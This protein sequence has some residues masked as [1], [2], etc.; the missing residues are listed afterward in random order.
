MMSDV[1]RILVVLAWLIPYQ[2]A[3]SEKMKDAIRRLGDAEAEVREKAENAI[4]EGWETWSDAD[5]AEL[6]KAGDDSD[7]ERAGRSKKALGDIVRLRSFAQHL[8][9]KVDKSGATTID[10]QVLAPAKDEAGRAALTRALSTFA[11]PPKDPT[12][13]K[14]FKGLR[15]FLDAHKETLFQHVFEVI[16][17]AEKV[18]PLSEVVVLDPARKADAPSEGKVL[19]F[20]IRGKGAQEVD[21]KDKF[22]SELNYH[23][24]TQQIKNAEI[25]E[26]RQKVASL[27]KQLKEKK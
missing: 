26:L 23:Y 9:V 20:V 14:T 17:V 7:R 4:L 18:T 19:L 25:E 1:C 2:D 22:V 5:L 8:L 13:K 3:A 27:E 16:A 10:G 6:K 15:L 11:E 24:Q 12:G 21:W